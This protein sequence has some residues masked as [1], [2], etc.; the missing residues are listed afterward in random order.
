MFLRQKKRNVD[1]RRS[2]DPSCGRQKIG[3]EELVIKEDV[4][5]IYCGFNTRNILGIMAYY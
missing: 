1:E 3:F 4:G 2:G 5:N